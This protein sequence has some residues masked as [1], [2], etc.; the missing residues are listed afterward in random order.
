MKRNE[1]IW[2]WLH[3]KHLIFTKHSHFHAMT[4]LF[5]FLIY[6]SRTRIYA[7]VSTWNRSWKIENCSTSEWK[8]VMRIILVELLNL[9]RRLAIL[10]SP[11]IAIS[12]LPCLFKK[13]SFSDKF[14]IYEY[15]FFFSF[16]YEKRRSNYVHIVQVELPQHKK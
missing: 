2:K 12:I 4:E 7:I 14:F 10:F 6:F 11:A 13:K 16:H 5:I 1:I 9:N 15:F 8:N 3:S